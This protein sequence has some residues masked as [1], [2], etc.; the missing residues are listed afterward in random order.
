VA[1]ELNKLTPQVEAMGQAMAVRQEDLQGRAAEALRV[2]NDRPEVTDEL[3]DKIARARKMDAWRRGATPLG[4][5][6]DEQCRVMN[7]QPSATLIAADGSQ[8]YPDRHGIATYYLLN[9]GTIVFRTG[10]GQAPS[11]ETAPTVF[12][13]DAELFDSE[14][15]VRTSD[16]IDAQRGRRELEALV[17]LAEAERE[18]AGGDMSVPIIALLDGPLLPWLPPGGEDNQIARDELGFFAEQMWR[19]RAARIVP[20]GY[21]DR[22]GSAF[23]L[24]ILELVDLPLERIDRETLRQ[25]RFRRLT[26]RLLFQELGPNTRSGLFTANSNANDRYEQISGGDRIAF[27]YLNVSRRPGTQNCIV[28]RIELPGWVAENAA[29]LDLAQAAVHDNCEPAGYPYVLARA[30]ELALVTQQERSDFEAMLVQSMLKN[31]LLPETSF[32]A[33]NKRLTGSRRRG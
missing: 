24:R 32:K 20:I 31:G 2:L 28:V 25:G 22:P 29:L 6:L 30:H 19:L 14:G 10:S 9:T 23:V 21:V 4:K 13:E 18:A 17:L 27:A 7:A 8:I 1:L 11:T 16:Y 15:Q 3:L 12:F 33:E 5:R 26:D